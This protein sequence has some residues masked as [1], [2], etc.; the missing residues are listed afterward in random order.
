MT[1]VEK[2][3]FLNGS[4]DFDTLNLAS[5]AF[6]TVTVDYANTNMY[7]YLSIDGIK[8]DTDLVVQ[9]VQTAGYSVYRNSD[10]VYSTLAGSVTQ[11]NT[12]NDIDYSVNDAY[13]RALTDALPKVAN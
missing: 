6:D 12:F 13:G 4:D 2:L 1:G 10:G 3:A 8:A 5:K 7:D 9:N 11:N